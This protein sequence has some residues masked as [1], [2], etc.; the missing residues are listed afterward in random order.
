MENASLITFS[1]FSPPQ[2]LKMVGSLSL[3]GAQKKRSPVR[4]KT[5]KSCSRSRPPWKTQPR[6]AAL[7]LRLAVPRIG[8]HHN[9]RRNVVTVSITTP[10][11]PPP[12][13][14]LCLRHRHRRSRQRQR[15]HCRPCHRCLAATIE[16]GT[17]AAVAKPAAAIPTALTSSALA[18]AALAVTALATASLATAGLAATSP[19]TTTSP[20]AVVTIHLLS[21]CRRRTAAGPATHLRSLATAA[22]ATAAI[23]IAAHTAATL[24]AAAS[25]P[26]P[27][28]ALAHN[29]PGAPKN[30]R[31]RGWSRGA[32]SHENCLWKH[33]NAHFFWS[34]GGFME[35]A[36]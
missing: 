31:D 8:R 32:F 23:A 1:T 36:S 10:P 28:L 6:P 27:P 14:R 19:A 9:Q 3:G 21:P 20:A 33:K 11:S 4:C 25:P 26:P 29:P 16:T 22:L 2:A 17:V 12:P 18:L 13:P 24:A 5:V 15:R 35:S 7:S 30:L 34:P